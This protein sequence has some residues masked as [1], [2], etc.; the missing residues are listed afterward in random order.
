MENNIDIISAMQIKMLDEVILELNNI[1]LPPE[2]RP[3]DVLGFA[4]K[5]IESKKGKL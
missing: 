5:K 4:I 3:K 2:W 1:E